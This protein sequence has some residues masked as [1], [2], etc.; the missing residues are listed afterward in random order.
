MIDQPTAFYDFCEMTGAS[1]PRMP[2][3]AKVV[4]HVAPFLECPFR[5]YLRLRHLRRP[6]IPD[7]ELAFR[8]FVFLRGR[9]CERPGPPRGETPLE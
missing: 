6:R 4:L 9:L 8:V 2:T 7:M 1:V 3:W 5:V